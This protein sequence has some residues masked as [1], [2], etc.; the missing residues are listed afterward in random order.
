MNTFEF[1]SLIFLLLDNCW[2]NCK[3]KELG[4]FLSEMNPYAWKTE[5][6]ADPAWYEE[7]KLFIKGK[8]LKQDNGFQLAKEYLRSITYYKG[9][10][11]YLDKYDQDDWNDAMKQ[12]LSQPHKGE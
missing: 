8:S 1:F 12:L 6:S 5:D 3:N 4:Q 9:L 10:E 11:K 7:F 2:D